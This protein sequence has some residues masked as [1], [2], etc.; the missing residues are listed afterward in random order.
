MKSFGFIFVAF[1]S[2][3]ASASPT[4][5]VRFT[6]TSEKAN[7]G[8]ELIDVPR[9][10]YQLIAYRKNNQSKNTL[11]V[12]KES[13]NRI[14]KAN[15]LDANTLVETDESV[16]LR[17]PRILQNRGT[18]LIKGRVAADDLKCR[19]PIAGPSKYREDRNQRRF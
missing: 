8:V 5:N 6:C 15:I 11:A 10:G 2:L 3:V 19:A 17:V 9:D 16:E 12:V 4:M 18:F 7:L 14:Y 1:M 13:K